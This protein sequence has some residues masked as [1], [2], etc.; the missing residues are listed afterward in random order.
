MNVNMWPGL[1]QTEKVPSEAAGEGDREEDKMEEG[2][3]D[4]VEERGM[5]GGYGEEG[6]VEVEEEEEEVQGQGDGWEQHLIRQEAHEGEGGMWGERSMTREAEE[7]VE[8]EEEEEEMEGEGLG[9]YTD[10]GREE[11]YVGEEEEAA[12]EITP[13]PLDQTADELGA[14]QNSLNLAPETED[15]TQQLYAT[16]P[17]SHKATKRLKMMKQAQKE[18]RK[19]RKK[20]L[21]M[22]EKEEKARRRAREKERKE[23]EK[24]RKKGIVEL[25]DMGEVM[26]LHGLDTK[27]SAGRAQAQFID[28]A[29]ASFF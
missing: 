10:E 1:P 9:R 13:A 4:E 15:D 26:K 27:T 22:E 12:P 23:H 28:A 8:E 2:V 20:K 19:A 5:E 24:Q 3:R 14:S 16:I 25:Q 17:E 7:E 11:R 18:E 21:K 6:Y 29:T